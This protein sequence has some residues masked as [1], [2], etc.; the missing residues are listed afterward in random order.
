MAR[1]SEKYEYV[2]ESNLNGN[3]IQEKNPN[4]YQLNKQ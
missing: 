1:E 3:Q 4:I 2:D